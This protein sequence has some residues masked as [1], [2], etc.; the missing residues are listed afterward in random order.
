MKNKPERQKRLV[1][2]INEHLPKLNG[3][4]ALYVSEK[5][6]SW[7]FSSTHYNHNPSSDVSQPLGWLSCD[8]QLPVHLD[9]A[10]GNRIVELR[11]SDGCVTFDCPLPEPPPPRFPPG[12]MMLTR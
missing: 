3:A 10:L 8:Q 12:Y 7:V 2:T 4:I 5:A 1:E 11:G 9:T 6:F